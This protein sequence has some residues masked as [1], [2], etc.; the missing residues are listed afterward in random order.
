[1]VFAL[2]CTVW[3]LTV[4]IRIKGHS[5]ASRVSRAYR[6]VSHRALSWLRLRFPARPAPEMCMNRLFQLAG[7]KA[8]WAVQNNKSTNDVPTWADL[9]WVGYRTNCP[10]GG[11]YKI[12]PVGEPPTCSL[13]PLAQHRLSP[14][15]WSPPDIAGLTQQWEKRRNAVTVDCLV[16]LRQIQTAKQQWA[17][18]NHKSNND[19]PTWDDIQPWVQAQLRCPFGGIYTIGRVGDRPTCSIAAQTNIS[20]NMQMSHELPPIFLKSRVPGSGF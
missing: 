8:Q 9:G 11:T 10:N 5:A 16:S 1:M 20:A 13:A 15:F 7:A 2:V 12:G 14:R 3:V 19:V 18:K 6:A 4:G 17:L